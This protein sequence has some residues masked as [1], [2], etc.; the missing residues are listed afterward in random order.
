MELSDA[1]RT[2]M[3][4]FCNGF[5]VVVG[6]VHQAAVEN[7]VFHCEGMAEFVIDHFYE[8]FHVYLGLIFFSFFSFVAIP[9]LDDFLKRNNTRPVL[10]RAKPKDPL[11]LNAVFW[12]SSI[13]D[14]QIGENGDRIS[15]LG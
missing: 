1:N 9:F 3:L 12:I 2:E 8:E 13:I 11:L 4:E 5:L 14:G 15:I 10:D 6:A 7:A